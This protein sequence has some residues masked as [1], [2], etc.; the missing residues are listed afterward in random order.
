MS[1][2]TDEHKDE[3]QLT[4]SVS[5]ELVRVG[6]EHIQGKFRNNVTRNERTQP[7]NQH[8][9]PARRTRTRTNAT[10]PVLR[11]VLRKLQKAKLSSESRRHPESSQ[12]DLPRNDEVFRNTFSSDADPSANCYHM[13]VHAHGV[14]HMRCHDRQPLSHFVLASCVSFCW[15]CFTDFDAK[16]S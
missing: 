1:K 8:S 10:R 3:S 12:Q 11:Q 13:F 15:N 9:P 14:C 16:T 7:N 6:N 4:K 5:R 2:S